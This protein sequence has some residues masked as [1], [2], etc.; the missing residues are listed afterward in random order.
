MKSM[1]QMQGEMFARC[2]KNNGWPK[3]FVHFGGAVQLI[4]SQEEWDRTF[5]SEVRM[6]CGSLFIVLVVCLWAFLA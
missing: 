5:K 6:M 1:K 3:P 4:H 2:F